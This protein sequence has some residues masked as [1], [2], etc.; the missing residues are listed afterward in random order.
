MSNAIRYQV[1]PPLSQ[2]E[3]Q[4]LHDD[5]R[6]NGVL[7]P[8]VEDEDG[9]IIDGHH[10]SKIASELGIPCPVETVS[11]KSDAE[12]RGMAFTLNLKRRHLDREQ[13][14][15]LIAE[16]L[17]TDPQLSNREHARRTG[18]SDK[19][20]GTLRGEME[21]SAEIPHFEKRVDPRTGNASQPT[22][23]PR[24]EPEPAGQ[25]GPDE[26]ISAANVIGA[27]DLAELNHPASE[28]APAGKPEPPK[29]RRSPI[30]DDANRIGW[31]IRT[32]FEK[33]EK[34]TEDDRYNT[35]KEKVT[36]LLRGH[37]QYTIE[38]AQKVL[39]NLAK[40]N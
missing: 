37:L 20:V 38:T 36:P 14:R 13:R 32:A 11:D 19:T 25:V 27:D 23:P 21:E 40:E 1:M 26:E 17:K 39:D 2:E 34:L 18:A 6:E 31:E 16:S 22:S 3:Y 7:V 28:P 9:V 15:A 5:I 8:I 30:T 29:P 12:K 24:R 4:E 35:N 33:L 10:R